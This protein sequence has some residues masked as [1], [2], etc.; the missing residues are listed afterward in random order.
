MKTLE[1]TAFLIRALTVNNVIF[2]C[3]RERHPPSPPLQIFNNNNNKIA[4]VILVNFF[5]FYLGVPVS[6]L[7]VQRNFLIFT[8]WI[9]CL[10]SCKSFCPLF[11]IFWP[12][13]SPSKTM[14]NIFI[15]SKKPF[16]FS[17]YSSF[18]NF[19]RSFHPFQVQKDKWKWNNLWCHELVCIN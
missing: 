4:K 15:S 2:N 9:I 17:R 10:Y 18:F 14:K 16:P 3:K 11:F 6:V 12:N 7:C 1:V 5:M 8:E 19:F 13:D